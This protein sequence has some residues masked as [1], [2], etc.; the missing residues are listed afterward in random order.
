[1]KVFIWIVTQKAAAYGGRP[2]GARLF[3]IAK[4]EAEANRLMDDMLPKADDM[5]SMLF[6]NEMHKAKPQVF[7]AAGFV[8]MTLNDGYKTRSFVHG[9]KL[10]ATG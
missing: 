3:I 8:E 7:D 9:N 10:G 2:G 4:D 6:R 5:N 1:M